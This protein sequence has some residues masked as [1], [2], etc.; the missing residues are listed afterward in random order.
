MRENGVEKVTYQ[1]GGLN[2]V[3]NYLE[4]ISLA[5]AVNCY[6]PRDGQ[7]SQGTVIT[8]LVINRLLAPC[9]LKNVAKWVSVIGG[10]LV[11]AGLSTI[12]LGR[13]MDIQE[14]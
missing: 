9:A 12:R 7:L 1:I 11:L 5:E 13:T 8:V 4:R 14:G 10:G 3:L 2:L 6:C